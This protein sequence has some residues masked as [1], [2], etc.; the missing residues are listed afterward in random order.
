MRNADAR[1]G[2]LP[3]SHCPR[4]LSYTVPCK[5]LVME[6]DRKTGGGGARGPRRPTWDASQV[7]ALRH[8]LG[9]SQQGLAEEMGTRQQTVSEWETGRY[10]PRGA[11]ARL[12]VII[13][14][15]AGFEYETGKG[16]EETGKRQGEMGEEGTD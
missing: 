1:P 11:S 8:H 5:L 6:A 14:E 7:R 9:L 15:R 10:R 16:Q 12:L 4:L 2:P 13:A 3:I